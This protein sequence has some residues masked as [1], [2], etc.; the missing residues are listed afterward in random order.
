MGQ[1]RVENR[2]KEKAE[3]SEGHIASKTGEEVA[4]GERRE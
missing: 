2:R 4:K 3:T 1:T